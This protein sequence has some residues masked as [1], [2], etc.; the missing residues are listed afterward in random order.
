MF[1]N[2][3]R[4]VYN[5][6]DHNIV[7]VRSIRLA[8]GDILSTGETVT[9]ITKFPNLDYIHVQL[10]RSNDVVQYDIDVLIKIKR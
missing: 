10:D 7:M 1:W 5:T 3:A 2:T 4:K 6:H 9:N 8:V